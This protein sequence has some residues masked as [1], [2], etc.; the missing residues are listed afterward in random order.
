MSISTFFP[1]L[2]VTA[3]TESASSAKAKRELGWMLRYPTWR[4]GFAAAYTPMTSTTGRKASR[5]GRSVAHLIAA[6]RGVA[7]R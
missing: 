2:T 6:T 1:P 5:A 3:P 7:V 4:E